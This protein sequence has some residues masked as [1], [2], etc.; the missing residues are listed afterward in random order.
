VSSAK[1]LRVLAIVA[2]DRTYEP[3]MLD[4]ERVWV[5][6]CIHCNSKLTIAD[7][8]TPISRATIEHIWP[9]T[10][11]GENDIEN[12]ALACAGCNRSKSHH[13]RQHKAN[14]KLGEIVEELRRRRADRWRDPAEV[15]LAERVAKILPVRNT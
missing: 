10:H 15:G 9:R 5:G 3:A 12:I 4:G 7:D 11:G 1:Q 8:G 13:D 6:K 14:E 2:T